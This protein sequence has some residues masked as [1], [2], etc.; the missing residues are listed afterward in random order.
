MSRRADREAEIAKCEAMSKAA[1]S[2]QSECDGL[3]KVFSGM[4]KAAGDPDGATYGKISTHFSKV[5]EAAAQM[6][7]ANDDSAAY[8]ADCLKGEEDTLGKTLRPDALSAIAPDDAPVAG[9]GYTAKDVRAVPRAGAPD[10]QINKAKVPIQFAHLVD[11]D[12]LF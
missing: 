1:A 8:H 7:S 9:F 2:M 10:T 5:A 3:S 6:K 4:Q 12:D 11:T